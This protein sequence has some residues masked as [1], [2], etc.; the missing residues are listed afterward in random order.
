MKSTQDNHD[1]LGIRLSSIINRLFLGERLFLSKLADEFGVHERTIYRDLHERLGCLDIVREDKHYYLS[2]N[3][4]G[5]R[6]TVNDI[7]QLAKITYI[8]RLFPSFDKELI[9]VLSGNVISPF[10]VY[11]PPPAEI[12][13]SFG[14][15]LTLTKAAIQRQS[16]HFVDKNNQQYHDYQLYRLIYFQQ[17]W[18][19]AGIVDKK[20]S[21]FSYQNVMNV[22]V[23]GSKSFDI[24]EKILSIITSESFFQCLPNFQTSIDLYLKAIGEYNK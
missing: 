3:Q 24:D 16:L 1:P 7:L 11:T 13:T 15:F 4:M 10:I 19:L 12:V 14:S 8:D 22:E 21:V 23:S 9:A 2:K 20:L 6:K 18:Y 5:S 17:K